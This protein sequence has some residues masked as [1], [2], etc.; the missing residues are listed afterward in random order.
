MGDDLRDGTLVEV[1]ADYPTMT[2]P[3]HTVHPSRHLLPRRITML[4]EAFAERLRG[5]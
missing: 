3:I 5:L 4:I 2:L 1:L